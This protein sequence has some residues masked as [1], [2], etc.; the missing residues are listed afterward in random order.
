M[1]HPPIITQHHDGQFVITG[2]DT[3]VGKTVF[4][5]ALTRALGAYYWKPVQAGL[6]DGTDTQSVAQLSGV[7]AAYILPEAY[8]LKTPCSPHQAAQIDAMPIDCDTL[9]VPDI[10]PLIIE[11]AGG[12]LVPLNNET[13]YADIFARWQIPTIIAARTSLGTINHSL[14]T[15]EALRRRNVPIFGIAFIGDEIIESQN[16]ICAIGQVRS[17]GR[18]PF[19]DVLNSENL[20]TAFD[21][22]FS[23]EDF[24]P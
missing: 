13:T 4:A 19:I 10:K 3:D 22:H 5:A 6:A 18:L 21:E 24:M 14:M 2:T 17:L 1:N 12:A 20:A 23:I 9:I 11:G 8:C 16:I 7:D 15:I